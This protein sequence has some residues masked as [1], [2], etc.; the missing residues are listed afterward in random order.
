MKNKTISRQGVKSVQYLVFASALTCASVSIA[1]TMEPGELRGMVWEAAQ[2]IE[3]GNVDTAR[4]MLGKAA[5]ANNLPSDVSA[6]IDRLQSNI[7]DLDLAKTEQ[8]PQEA[9]MTPQEMENY[10]DSI[11]EAVDSL[12]ENGT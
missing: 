9:G 5:A 8:A 2:E 1:E 3:N 12:F 11:S 4:V 7:L 10:I 6:L